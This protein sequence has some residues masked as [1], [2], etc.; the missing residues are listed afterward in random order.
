MATTDQTVQTS[1]L[2]LNPTADPVADVADV[3]EG[4]EGQDKI[5]IFICASSQDPTDKVPILYSTENIGFCIVSWL[6]VRVIPALSSAT[7][8]KAIHVEKHPEKDIYSF[9]EAEKNS[10]H[11]IL[12]IMLQLPIIGSAFSLEGLTHFKSMGKGQRLV[13]TPLLLS[14]PSM[15][16]ALKQE[17]LKYLA[18]ADSI[19]FT[20][21]ADKKEAIALC[22]EMD[23]GQND[24]LE[25]IKLASI[26]SEL[27][28]T[29]P[30][31]PAKE[32]AIL[33]TDVVT[34]PT[35]EE[36]TVTTVTT[37][38]FD[39]GKVETTTETKKGNSIHR[40]TVIENVVTPPPTLEEEIPHLQ[41]RKL[42]AVY[43]RTLVDNDPAAKAFLEWRA[44]FRKRRAYSKFA[45]V[46]KIN[47]EQ[48]SE[49]NFK[50]L[51]HRLKN[52]E[53]PYTEEMRQFLLKELGASR[54]ALTLPESHILV[55]LLRMPWFIKHVSPHYK[56]IFE[57]GNSLI[58]LEQRKRL[59]QDI[60]NSHTNPME[61]NTD[62]AFLTLNA[63]DF[64]P[65][66]FLEDVETVIEGDYP[67]LLETNTSSLK[68]LWSSGHIY[69]FLTEQDGE[70]LTIF[71]SRLSVNYRK[72]IDEE[73]DEVE[74]FKECVFTHPDGT[75]KTL[76]LQKQDEIFVYPKIDI[77]FA[78]M[79]IEKLRLLGKETYDEIIRRVPAPKRDK[80]SK[81]DSA[82]SKENQEGLENQ[83]DL[84]VNQEFE[85]LIQDLIQ[86]INHSGIL[87]VHKP[88]ELS[89]D[90]PEISVIKRN[91]QG[92]GASRS[93]F[94]QL[95]PIIQAALR[96][97]EELV[98]KLLDEIL[99]LNPKF[100]LE[101]AIKITTE[102]SINLL[103][104]CIL[105]GQLS[106]V[107]HLLNIGYKVHAKELIVP[108]NKI[109]NDGST[110]CITVDTL[111]FVVAL[112]RREIHQAMLKAM[113]G[114]TYSEPKIAHETIFA[115]LD[116][117]QKGSFF[118]QNRN[119]RQPFFMDSDDLIQ[120]I[121]LLRPD[122]E[123]VQLLLRNVNFK[124]KELSLAMAASLNSIDI[125]AKYI[126]LG[127]EV[128][129]CL[130]PK[131]F[132]RRTESKEDI[133]LPQC[134]PLMTAIRVNNPKMVE[135]LLKN[136]A[137]VNQVYSLIY[138]EGRDPYAARNLEEE[139]FTPLLFAVKQGNIDI[140]QLLLAAG[141]NVFHRSLKGKSAL[142]IAKE[143]KR[144]DIVKVL[145]QH[146]QTVCNKRFQ[147][148]LL[149]A[150]AKD[151]NWELC[152]SLIQ[153]GSP[154]Y[155]LDEEG[156]TP[157]DVNPKLLEQPFVPLER[158]AELYTAF[159]HVRRNIMTVRSP[160]GER[161]FMLIV[162]KSSPHFF[163]FGSFTL[164]EDY[165]SDI[166]ESLEEICQ[167][168]IAREQ[169]IWQPLGTVTAG[170]PDESIHYAD[171]WEFC[172][173]PS[174]M[175]EP[176]KSISGEEE[177]HIELIS[178]K[179]MVN[180]INQFLEF[181]AKGALFDYKDIPIFQITAKLLD[182]LIQQED[183]RPFDKKEL[184][185]LRKLYV[186]QREGAHQLRN[187]I[188]A[189]D[190]AGMNALLAKTPLCLE[191]G[192]PSREP[193]PYGDSQDSGFLPEYY[194]AKDTPLFWALYQEKGECT[195]ALLAD[196]LVNFVSCFNKLPY[197]SKQFFQDKIF[198]MG[199]LGICQ[200][201]IDSI[202]KDDTIDLDA[203]LNGILINVM[204]RAPNLE[205]LQL[206]ERNLP[207]P[208]NI[209]TYAQQAGFVLCPQIIEYCLSRFSKE[210]SLPEQEPLI[211]SLVYSVWLNASASYNTE[212]TP[213]R[214]T[215]GVHYSF[216]HLSRSEI[217]ENIVKIANIC[218]SFSKQEKT[219][220]QILEFL[221]RKPVEAE[222]AEIK[223][224]ADR[225]AKAREEGER[226]A[227]IRQQQGVLFEKAR[228]DADAKRQQA[229][230]AT[231]LAE[232]PKVTNE[233]VR[234]KNENAAP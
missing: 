122:P 163:P 63:G 149:H 224:K 161:Y 50:A 221:N 90:E 217:S 95:L 191:M 193:L 10:H 74:W 181:R 146:I 207:K 143:N 44:D 88:A 218:L 14:H 165:Q 183:L 148:T 102:Y 23:L 136:K 15:T 89:L 25:K 228:L 38:L 40:S 172:E 33:K 81:A 85:R 147:T 229:A 83:E 131:T 100:P 213:G 117:I 82:D 52:V 80:K 35:E 65:V 220:N 29:N 94:N 199:H 104:A 121:S 17:T 222:N 232:P 233:P 154:D 21:E 49:I 1:I 31:T 124:G 79:L 128:N 92:R 160:E 125:V 41:F 110:L 223:A 210:H 178:E 156:R 162:N 8:F 97:E 58:S 198:A 69:A 30:K 70:P 130:N 152:E 211:A 51:L 67:K 197:Y 123:I 141:A 168:R 194:L 170:I 195:Y 139:G 120:I 186:E 180:L 39:N 24:L 187:L 174:T 55:T 71:A 135:F 45:E 225:E 48:Q 127:A 177:Y 57:N 84:K 18:L 185:E 169:I 133:L 99:A 208:L 227:A 215:P 4:K 137:D 176:I 101:S 9:I 115:L 134:F 157:Y 142:A 42:F 2:G 234:N 5:K 112:T 107:S 72:R 116:L 150:A 226:E 26:I 201:F 68:G 36:G 230:L 103:T 190:V 206:I 27:N 7:P 158:Q 19:V 76:I 20:N 231:V 209:E 105:G 188:K 144:D 205:L 212:F 179:E 171:V 159:V 106:L 140:I 155:A 111:F 6:N 113:L 200:F 60:S 173:F 184:S 182:I 196:H 12:H 43:K 37:T 166:I 87:E 86:T 56:T 164:Q 145:T 3:K 32:P 167:E 126:E 108:K 219:R 46:Q 118:R 61:G 66:R 34:L 64:A 203:F 78:L 16:K 216:S 114:D 93:E 73:T 75:K 59:H 132:A 138:D 98:L 119:I 28:F 47:I 151:S 91:I 189:G 109:L 13:I 22:K 96:G 202:K 204:L 54:R 77:A 153:A 129:E 62:N 53:G 11:S 214:K 175:F 192:I